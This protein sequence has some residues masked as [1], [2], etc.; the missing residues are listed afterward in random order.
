MCARFDRCQWIRSLTG[1]RRD[2][3]WP[4]L[5]WMDFIGLCALGALLAALFSVATLL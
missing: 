4:K 2:S 5:V 1:P 3:D